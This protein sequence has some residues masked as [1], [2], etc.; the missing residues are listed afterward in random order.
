MEYAQILCFLGEIYRDNEQTV[1]AI[2]ALGKAI[3]LHEQTEDNPHGHEDPGMV[4]GVS[5]VGKD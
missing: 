5:H 1:E 4:S 2:E 3:R